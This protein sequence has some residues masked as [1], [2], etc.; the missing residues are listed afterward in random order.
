MF[1]C[2]ENEF[3]SQ[4]QHCLRVKDLIKILVHFSDLYRKEHPFLVP[5][6]KLAQTSIIALVSSTLISTSFG[7]P[8]GVF[9][10]TLAKKESDGRGS[11][12]HC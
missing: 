1:A 7:S 11:L 2:S 3:K 4:L 8:C 9:K 6:F 12:F 10:T 5:S